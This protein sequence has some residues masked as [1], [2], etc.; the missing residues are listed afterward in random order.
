MAIR[1][2]G[3]EGSAAFQRFN[4]S[5]PSSNIGQRSF[6]D[7]IIRVGRKELLKLLEELA[8]PSESIVLRGLSFENKFSPAASLTMQN[9]VSDIENTTSF[10]IKA[11]ESM[12]RIFRDLAS[13][14]SGK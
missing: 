6:S 7:E 9:I 14:A 11:E 4:S 8:S 5:K 3:S 1:G 13:S 2:I 10:A 12:T